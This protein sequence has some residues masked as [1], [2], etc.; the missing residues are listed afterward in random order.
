MWCLETLIELNDAVQKRHDN[1]ECP[2]KGY[3]DVGISIPQ[4][5]NVLNFERDKNGKKDE[6]E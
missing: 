3:S 4:T 2:L 6:K 1:N 5:R